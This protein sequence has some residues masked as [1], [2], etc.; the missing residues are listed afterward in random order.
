MLQI[1]APVTK[2]VV[3][4]DRETQVGQAV[5]LIGVRVAISLCAYG[6]HVQVSRRVN[7]SITVFLAFL[8]G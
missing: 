4:L 1:G 7:T 6:L 5:F 8:S 2:Q 3:G